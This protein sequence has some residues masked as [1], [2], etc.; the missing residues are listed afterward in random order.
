MTPPPRAWTA[1]RYL[2]LSACGLAGAIGAWIFWEHGWARRPHTPEAAVWALASIAGLFAA[3]RAIRRDRLASWVT[4]LAVPL[5]LLHALSVLLLLAQLNDSWKAAYRVTAPLTQIA[6]FRVALE[7]FETDCGH[8]PST[9][10]G[11]AP[12]IKRP[13]DIP[14]SV[15]RGPYLD[16]IP[17]DMWG[18]DFIYRCPGQHDTNGFD[19]YSLGP[20]GVSKTGGD[21]P[22]D[23]NNWSHW[24]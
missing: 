23:V 20:D 11:L 3:L 22:D 18:H 19:I 4:E 7:A 1:K 13:P 2:L 14:E 17:K 9:A 15:W 8:L 21:D 10:E 16:A 6:S 24:Q 12:L 5:G